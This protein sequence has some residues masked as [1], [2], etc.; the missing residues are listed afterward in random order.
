MR[1]C[2]ASA[3]ERPR[4]VNVERPSRRGAF[5][6]AVGAVSST[7]AL[8]VGSEEVGFDVK[9]EEMISPWGFEALMCSC[10][11]GAVF[12][13]FS[14]RVE[15]SLLSELFVTVLLLVDKTNGTA[16]APPLENS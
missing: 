16:L 1:R 6:A 10:G 14:G 13:R 3:R 15:I 7:G 8:E 5:E 12:C 4:D 11:A 2:A 9:S